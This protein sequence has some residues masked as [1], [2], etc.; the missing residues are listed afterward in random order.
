MKD[1]M[2]KRAR[3]TNDSPNIAIG[4]MNSILSEPAK[5][6]LPNQ[7][8]LKTMYKMQRIAPP[9]PASLEELELDAENIKT[10]SDR[11]FLF[12]D[13]GIGPHRIVIFATKEN[14]EF[15]S[16]SSIWLADGTFKTVHTLFFQLYTI[17]FLVGGPNP[18]ENGHLL[19]CVY[20]LLP[21]KSTSTNTRM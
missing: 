21:N 17:H 9:N 4:E 8:A 14:L 11:N 12:Y 2:R 15:L 1:L 18:F 16:M 13:S 10:F 6:L 19:P 3:E 20:A 7:H 5:Y